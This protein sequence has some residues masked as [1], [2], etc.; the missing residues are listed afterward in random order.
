[1][2]DIAHLTVIYESQGYDRVK[3]EVESL[4]QAGAQVEAASSKAA[5]G[6]QRAGAAAAVAV[7]ASSQ[8]VRA[9]TQQMSGL[10]RTVRGLG[11][12]FKHAFGGLIAF[13]T[14]AAMTEFARSIVDANRDMQKMLNTLN[15]ASGSMEQA[16]GEFSF[17]T[18]LANKLGTDLQGSADGYA[19]LAVS[20]RSAGISTAQLH[21]SFTGLSEGFAATGRSGDEM[22]RFLVQMEQGLSQGTIQMRDLR[23]MAQSFPS[24]F[25][26]AGEAA[27]RMGGS[28]D[29]FLKQGGLPAQQFFVTFSEIVHEK[30]AKAA[31]EASNTLIG[32]L[33][34]IKNALFE[35]KTAGDVLAP[36]TAA[37]KALADELSSDSGR[38]HIQDLVKNIVDGFKA[39]LAA[40]VAFI[41]VLPELIAALKVLA[42]IYA[43]RLVSGGIGAFR[44]A[45]VATTGVIGGSVSVLRVLTSTTTGLSFGMRAAAVS[46]RA[47]GAALALVGG[48]VGLAILALGAAYELVSHHMQD[49]LA[50]QKAEVDA[51]EKQRSALHAMNVKITEYNKSVGATNALLSDVPSLSSGVVS[52]NADQAQSWLALAHATL[53]SNKALVQAKL[54]AGQQAADRL[55]FRQNLINTQ[56]GG[57]NPGAAALGKVAPQLLGTSVA[58]DTATLRAG[59]MAKNLQTQLEEQIKAVEKAFGSTSFVPDVRRLMDQSGMTSKMEKYGEAVRKLAGEMNAA[60]KNGM[61]P[62]RAAEAFNKGREALEKI[63]DGVVGAAGSVGAESALDRVIQSIGKSTVEAQGPLGEYTKH[64]VDLTKAFDDDLAHGMSL[65]SA[66][67]KWAT[68]HDQ[69][70]AALKRETAALAAKHALEI[71]QYK[72][73]LAQAIQLRAAQGLLSN[74]QDQMGPLQFQ[75]QQQLLQIQQQYNE[76]IRS[77]QQQR[78]GLAPGTDTT[79]IDAQIKAQEIAQTADLA[80]QQQLYNDKLEQMQKILPGIKGGFQE[81]ADTAMNLT[82]QMHQAVNTFLTG[83]ADGLSTVLTGGKFSFKELL[84][85][86]LQA[87]NQMI[88]RWLVFKAITAIGKSMGVDP[89]DNGSNNA[90]AMSEAAKKMRMAGLIVGASAFFMRQAA[91]KLQTAAETLAFAETLAIVA[92]VAAK[93]AVF[94]TG[95]RATAFASGGI[96]NSPTLFQ[97]AGGTGLMGEAGPEAIMPLKRDSQGRLGVQAQGSK[98]GGRPISIN[99]NIDA[100]GAGPDEMAK[101]AQMRVETIRKVHSDIVHYDKY[102]Y[103]PSPA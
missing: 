3:G 5:T 27:K 102:G 6:T 94:D 70:T 86:F 15:A 25:E 47:L 51:L 22:N 26:I 76:R 68:G 99:Y 89:M 43:V 46:S 18:G 11:D 100:R 61:D 57:V 75:Q 10:E 88:V 17:L 73:N 72:D 20:A 56:F 12:V 50:K 37:F 1:M 62:A 79:V 49:V 35:A 16:K 4:K 33:N 95:G 28:L 96:V 60:I 9:L 71:R 59:I 39:A 2:A 82:G 19:R 84:R 67:A 103:F 83:F 78:A 85:S 48:P 81:F 32:Q 63:R 77:L 74:R 54:L 36:L 93:G 29:S 101:L 69:I 53:E 14:V 87:I 52:A 97:F 58:G 40:V 80:A 30:F 23:A 41:Q 64:M 38:Q 31:E 21:K 8:R 55:A 13:G 66:M 45:M 44:N 24:A 7:G 91:D 90:E 42:T 65:Q 98:E 34:R 92:K